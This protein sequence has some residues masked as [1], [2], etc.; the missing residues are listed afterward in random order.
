MSSNLPHLIHLLFY[1]IQKDSA[2][3]LLDMYETWHFLYMQKVSL[4]PTGKSKRNEKRN[5]IEDLKFYKM[6]SPK[7]VL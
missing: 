7:G 3:R 5:K 1:Y 6:Q 2:L 4:F